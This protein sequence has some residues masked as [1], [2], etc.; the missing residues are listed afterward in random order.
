MLFGDRGLYGISRHGHQTPAGHHRRE[1]SPPMPWP[2]HPAR[3]PS[4]PRSLGRSRN[5]INQNC[6]RRGGL[7][8]PR[9]MSRLL[10]SAF[11]VAQAT[12]DRPPAISMSVTVALR[13]AY[14]TLGRVLS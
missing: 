11:V 8:V 7:W 3:N 14:L 5:M 12:D 10:T 1:I 4:R 6:E 9:T 13:L 2:G